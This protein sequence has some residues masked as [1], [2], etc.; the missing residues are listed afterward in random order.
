MPCIFSSKTTKH[1]LFT[2]IN[3]SHNPGRFKKYIISYIHMN[4]VDK[5]ILY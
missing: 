5:Y 2:L 3:N 4:G 1:A